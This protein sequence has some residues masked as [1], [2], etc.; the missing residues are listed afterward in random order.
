MDQEVT[1]E[2]REW[3]DS[4]AS[5]LSLPHGWVAQ[6]EKREVHACPKLY[7]RDAPVI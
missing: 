4:A 7:P 2:G 3:E 1:G 6:T 5:L